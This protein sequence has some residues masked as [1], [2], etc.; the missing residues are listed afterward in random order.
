MTAKLIHFGWD[1]CY[2]IGVLRS[3]GFEVIESQTLAD[4]EAELR[5]SP[6]YDAV[7]LSEVQDTELAR[8]L[9]V[10][11]GDTRAPMVL[12]RRNSWDQLD[13]KQFDVVVGELVNS[14]EWLRAIALVI[15]C[16]RVRAQTETQSVA[17]QARVH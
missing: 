14:V 13:E 7:V 4:L 6:H 16:Y 8:V 9:T 1:G 5:G 11:R 10:A 3:M 12:F 15:E 17:R 2:R